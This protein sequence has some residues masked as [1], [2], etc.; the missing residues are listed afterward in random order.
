M[1][2]LNHGFTPFKYHVKHAIKH[3][4]IIKVLKFS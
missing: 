4:G 2:V 1:N 3:A